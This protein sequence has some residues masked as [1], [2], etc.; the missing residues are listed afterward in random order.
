[1]AI[2]ELY[3]RRVKTHPGP[4]DISFRHITE[5]MAAGEV[6]A[7]LAECCGAKEEEFKRRCHGSALRALAARFLV[8]YS[9]LSQREVAD[10]LDAGSGAAVS[11]QLAR[12]PDKLAGDRELRRLVEQIELRLHSAQAERLKANEKIK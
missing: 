2:D 7:V 1:L 12:L 8:K 6:L 4:E 11:N 3:Q 9:G 10:L 5:P